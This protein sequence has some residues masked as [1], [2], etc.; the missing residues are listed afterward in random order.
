MSS[1]NFELDNLA[2]GLQSAWN[3][4]D[5][6]KFARYFVEDADFV[7]ILGGH[8]SGRMNI[9]QAHARI[10]QTIYLDSVVSYSIEGVRWLGPDSAVVRMFQSLEY[11]LI[12]ARQKMQCRPTAVAQ[13]TPEGW[14]IALMQNTRISEPEESK[15][16]ELVRAHPFAPKS[17]RG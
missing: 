17:S 10:F 8:G 11:G 7:H 5:A 14:K 15:T 13:K 6:K 9:E 3:A 2:F 16:A 4:A 12:G 1:A